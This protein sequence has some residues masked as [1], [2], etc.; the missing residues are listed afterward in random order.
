MNLRRLEERIHGGVD[1]DD[2][3]G[4]AE[5]VEETAKIGST[6]PEAKYIW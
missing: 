5:S 4:G 1:L 6:H 2:V 3:V